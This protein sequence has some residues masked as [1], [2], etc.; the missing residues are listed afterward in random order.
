MLTARQNFLDD[1]TAQLVRSIQP[2][3]STI[4]SPNPSAS[5][6]QAVAEH[7]RAIATAVGGV[8]AKTEATLADGDGRLEAGAAAALRRHA[9]PVLG[10]L[11]AAVVEMQAGLRERGGV[12]RIPPVA[13]RVA[14]ATKE[15]VL[16]VERIEAGEVTA[17]TELP[18]EF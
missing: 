11:E 10:V 3:V 5:S 17:A 12:E 2:L 15:L 1:S 13:F 9:P 16:R 18:A 7:V 4:R 8:V 6:T 14:R